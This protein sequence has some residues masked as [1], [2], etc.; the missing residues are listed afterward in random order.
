MLFFSHMEGLDPNG[1]PTLKAKEKVVHVPPQPKPEVI[2][3]IPD[4][5]VKRVWFNFKGKETLKA[6][7]KPE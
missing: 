5:A 6:E 2:I 7:R 1:K 3:R 4:K